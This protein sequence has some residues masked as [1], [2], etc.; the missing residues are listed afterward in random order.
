MRGSLAAKALPALILAACFGLRTSAGP[1]PVAFTNGELL[2][3]PTD[4]FVTLNMMPDETIEY[5]FEYGDRPGTYSGR[6]S[7]ARAEGGAP[8]EAVLSPLQ[9][10]TKYYYRTRV[11]RPGE[12]DFAAREERTFRT[13]P[14]AGKSFVFD[15]EADPHLD[16]NSSPD[17]YRRTLENIL[18]DGPDFLVDLGDTF[19]SEKQPVV[20]WNT[21]LARHLLFRTYFDRTCH[22][23]PLFFALGNHEGEWG[24]RL[25]GTEDN[26][27]VWATKARKMFYPNPVPDF[28]YSGNTADE[29]FVGL[30]QDYYAWE[31]GNALFVVLDPYWYTMVKS[32][33]DNWTVT[34]GE[35]QYAWLKTVLESSAAKFKF[36]FCH[37]LVGGN[38]KDGR[39]GSEYA[40]YY[41]WGGRNSDG[42]W[43]F[44]AKRP[45]WAQPIHQ[46]MVKT[47]VTAFFHGHDHFYGK[48]S[49]DGI[50]YQVVPQP[51]HVGDADPKASEYGYV[52]GKFIGGSGHLRVTV[53]ADDVYVEF[54]RSHLPGQG[55]AAEIADAYSVSAKT[56][57]GGIRR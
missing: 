3:R 50:V 26:V 53:S 14:P 56:K 5:Y 36:V 28:F 48:Q 41:E 10:D 29:R 45:G 38:T 25:T 34:L 12:T 1:A 32:A 22:S 24:D 13:R 15:I 54:I 52:D 20:N 4:R 44:T 40:G 17:L 46:L 27:A 49:L 35:V 31:W 30:R 39:G 43:G 11:R 57:K 55:A 42:S 2:G 47:G 9:P 21:V 16:E 7:T 23:V 8:F 37:Q 51:S 33:T 6:T 18:A 19:F